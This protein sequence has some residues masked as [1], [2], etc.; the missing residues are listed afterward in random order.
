[1]CDKAALSKTTCAI[2]GTE[3]LAPRRHPQLATKLA[4]S[5]KRAKISRNV[6]QWLNDLSTCARPIRGGIGRPVNSES[7][8]RRTR[9]LT[10]C[11]NTHA[12]NT[13][14][15]YIGHC[16]HQAIW[17]CARA[18]ALCAAVVQR[19]SRNRYMYLHET[20]SRRPDIIELTSMRPR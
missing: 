15:T 1:M 12:H 14:K 11:N 6:S 16:D 17:S 8:L 7:E 9:D 13:A 10:G 3:W 18:K 19:E 4:W 20:P 2:R 5:K